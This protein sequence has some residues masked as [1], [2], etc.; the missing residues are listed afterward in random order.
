M[1][2]RRK[3]RDLEYDPNLDDDDQISA[4]AVAASYRTSPRP[5]Q[6]KKIKIKAIESTTSGFL[7]C[8]VCYQFLVETK[9]CRGGHN[10]CKPCYNRILSEQKKIIAESPHLQDAIPLVPC[11][12]CRHRGT[13]VNN[14]AL[15]Q[16]IREL[17]PIDSL[18]TA[19]ELE[20]YIINKLDPKFKL[21][22][23]DAKN[24]E[25][26]RIVAKAVQENELTR[27]ATLLT[28]I[29]RQFGNNSGMRI[30][31]AETKENWYLKVITFGLETQLTKHNFCAFEFCNSLYLVRCEK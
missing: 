20:S 5:R 31:E 18:R 14:P 3:N 29:Q 4:T 19:S 7:E 17:Y 13:W 23:C 11:P 28:K 27:K 22:Y 10:I 15:D 6:P 25:V 24:W 9:M 16:L 2:G 21:I 30:L 12:M 1:L 8:P 26:L